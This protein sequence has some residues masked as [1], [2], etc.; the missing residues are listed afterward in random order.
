[1]RKH[2]S[3]KP[4][5]PK[6]LNPKHYQDEK[7]IEAIVVIEN[8]ELGFNEGSALKYIGRSKHKGTRQEDLLKAANYLFREAT[9]RW[10]PDE[11]MKP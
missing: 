10:L 9:G 5:K 7:R 6:A 4:E 8:W 1:M 11:V 2:H 3:L